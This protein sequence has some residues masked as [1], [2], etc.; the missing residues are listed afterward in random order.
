MKHV[1]KHH[2]LVDTDHLGVRYDQRSKPRL[3]SSI[4]PKA[5][6]G[7]MNRR[8]HNT[9]ENTSS[10]IQ[11]KPMDNS[12]TAPPFDLLASLYL[13]G[14]QRAER[15]VIVY[16][17]PRHRDFT[18]PDGKVRFRARWVQGKDGAVEEHAWVFKDVGIET[19]FD[20]MLI[21]GSHRQANRATQFDEDSMTAAMNA[22]ELG[23]E[24]NI[25]NEEKSNVGQIVMV[26]ER[27]VVGVKWNED[28][29]R[30][31]HR[32]DQADDVDMDDLGNG[33]THTTMYVKHTYNPCIWDANL[34]R[35][36]YTKTIPAKPISLVNYWPY[37][38]G[39]GPYA[40]FQFF[41]RS[42]G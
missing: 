42:Q 8:S 9:Q 14:R 39:E 23:P 31:K 26:I 32:N 20:K 16:L 4:S 5:K 18:R 40:T 12:D 21:A 6:D 10:P 29:Y 35:P 13:D 37:R 27:I 38:D 3:S 19:I 33:I 30:P 17:D 41:Y 7:H 15:R 22:T 36:T 24:G 11:E 2:A 1:T 25:K 28:N 34:Y